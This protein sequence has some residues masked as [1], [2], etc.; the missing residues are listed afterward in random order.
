MRE[1][2]SEAPSVCGVP[3]SPVRVA[4][5]TYPLIC[6]ENT[7]RVDFPE[8]R[9]SQREPDA[10]R[11]AKRQIPAVR[12][13]QSEVSANDAAVL[14]VAP[15]FDYFLPVTVEQFPLANDDHSF[16]CYLHA[17]CLSFSEVFGLSFPSFRCAYYIIYFD[18]VSSAKSKKISMHEMLDFI[19]R[20]ERQS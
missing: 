3:Q 6:R 19:G 7:Y 2:V 15:V 5:W 20:N 12:N 13:L 16:F 17:F 4:P 18:F 8:L 9:C 14:H 11:L 1:S 10:L